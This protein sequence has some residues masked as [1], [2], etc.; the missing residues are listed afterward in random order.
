M[1]FLIIS[2]LFLFPSGL[3]QVHIQVQDE[4]SS[5]DYWHKS[6]TALVEEYCEIMDL[7]DIV[8]HLGIY[9]N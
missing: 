1:L 5:R 3:K 6:V 2:N 7:F 9:K 4:E 8:F